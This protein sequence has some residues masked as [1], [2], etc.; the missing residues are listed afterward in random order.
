MS[1]RHQAE[2]AA[3]KVQEVQ[4]IQEAG[5]ERALDRYQKGQLQQQHIQD[6]IGQA[7]AIERQAS[8]RKAGIPS[9]LKPRLVEGPL[10]TLVRQGWTI[11]V[12]DE[13]L[14]AA[15]GILGKEA[16][17]AEEDD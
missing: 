9:T 11:F 3:L 1:A 2:V 5:I 14:K 15:R 17:D 16:V 13:H 12:P 6:N 4:W 10:K 8:L 7:Q